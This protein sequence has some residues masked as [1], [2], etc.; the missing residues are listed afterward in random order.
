MVTDNQLAERVSEMSTEHSYSTAPQQVDRPAPYLAPSKIRHE[1]FQNDNFVTVTV[2]IKGT[3]PE[4]VAV[5][6]FERSLS[7]TVRL[8]TG[9]DYSLELDPLAHSVVPAESKY[10]VMS[11]K[12]EIKLKKGEPGIKW[13]AL[14][15]EEQGPVGQISAA[16][17]AAPPAYPSSARVKHDWSKLEKEVTADKAE[18]DEALNNFFQMLYK[19]ADEDTRRAMIKSY[20][21]SGGTALSTNWSEVGKKRVEVVPPDGM[22]R[23]RCRWCFPRLTSGSRLRRSGMNEARERL[24]TNEVEECTQLRTRCRQ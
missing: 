9:A 18:G 13:G 21:E 6:M 23:V 3:R 7:I 1:W 19:D 12:I 5:N 17:A 24:S 11:T 16:S 8:P 20:T 14:E 15:G 10:S 4:D 22:V 2:F